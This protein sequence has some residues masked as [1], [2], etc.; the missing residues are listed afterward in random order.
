MDLTDISY[1]QALVDL[2]IANNRV[3]ELSRKIN[4]A[5]AELA[6][7][8][9]QLAKAASNTPEPN[10]SHTEAPRLVT[11]GNQS[12][13]K[14]PLV[15]PGLFRTKSSKPKMITH[16]DE[17]AGSP[18]S[19]TGRNTITMGQYRNLSISG[20]AIPTGKR[21]PFD[22]I[23]VKISGKS[24]SIKKKVE[25]IERPDVATHFSNPT[26][27]NSGFRASFSISELQTGLYVLEIEGGRSGS[28]SESVV[29]GEVE[30]R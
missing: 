12:A 16:I 20:W 11:T 17:I 23:E 13:A 24:S 18:P 7:L 27:A 19:P 21:A 6:K 2:T 26:L 15:L 25:L 28:P 14:A 3:V 30:V 10:K 4:D 22:F 9:A 1:E 29:V 5:S 8:H